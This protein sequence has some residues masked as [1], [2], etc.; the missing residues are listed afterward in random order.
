MIANNLYF[1]AVED[2]LS[3]FGS[4]RI[5]VKGTSMQPLLRDGVD[6]VSL[7]PS[8][9]G[10]LKRFDIVLFRYR[11]GYVLHRLIRKRDDCLVFQGDNSI[12]AKEICPPPAVIAKVTEIHRPYPMRLQYILSSP[13]YA[14]MIASIRRLCRRFIYRLRGG[15]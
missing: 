15:L 8:C 10:D 7:V 14:Y 2:S 4:V 1:K 3:R 13:L 6:E 11:D 12:Y 5:S 9:A